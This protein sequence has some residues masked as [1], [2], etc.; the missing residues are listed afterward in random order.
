LNPKGEL[1]EEGQYAEGDLQGL[2]K[3]YDNGTLFSE[4]EYKQGK[5]A[6]VYRE[7]YPTGEV[8]Q[9]SA[10]VEGKLTGTVQV[11]Y[12]SGKLKET[13]TL[14]NGL[15]TGT[16]SIYEPDGKIL[17]EESYMQNQLNGECKYY[18]QGVLRQVDFYQDG[19]MYKRQIYAGE[20]NL[21]IEYD[22]TG[23]NSGARP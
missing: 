18:K 14:D 2:I 15:L 21:E 9:V 12:K 23:Q 22:Y 20:G 8:S 13:Y 7:Y 1:L 16:K 19:F 6:G 5:K 11:F 10:W 3:I 4:Q 17:A